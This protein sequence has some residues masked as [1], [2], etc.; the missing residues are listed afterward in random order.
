MP[1]VRRAV[2]AS[3]IPVAVILGVLGAGLA[4]IALTGSPTPPSASG[5]L[6]AGADPVVQ[7]SPSPGETKEPPGRQKQQGG[8]PDLITGQILPES[9]PVAVS[10]PK[11][12]VESELVDLRIDDSGAM[13]VPVEGADAGWYALGPTPGALGPAVIAGHVTWDQ[14]P[15]VFYDLKTLKVGDEV[16]VTR[17]DGRTAIFSVEG[18]ETFAKDRFPTDTVFGTIDHAGLRLITC[19][20]TYD[21]AANRYLDN[22]VVFASLVDVV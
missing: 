8:V 3:A 19:G 16:K 14:S 22:V 1:E 12:D 5:V 11:L 10:I 9:H 21:S 2:R 20:G 18:V 6:V 17:A 4:G 13:E 15:A 7:P